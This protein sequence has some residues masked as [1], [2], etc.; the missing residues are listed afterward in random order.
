M[1][2]RIA[3]CQYRLPYVTTPYL[4]SASQFDKYQARAALHARTHMH[5]HACNTAARLP[6]RFQLPYNEGGAMPPYEPGT[7]QLAFADG[8]Q[9]L[10][11]SVVLNLPTATQPRS[12]VF[13]SACFKHCTSNM[14]A[15]WGVRVDDVSLAAY[16][17]AWYFDAP[18]LLATAGGKQALGLPAGVPAQRIEACIGF[19]CGQCHSRVAVGGPPLP[20]A[21]T[22][23]LLAPGPGSAPSLMGGIDEVGASSGA[24]LAQAEAQAPR[25]LRT[26]GRNATAREAGRSAASQTRLK[27]HAAMVVA[28]AALVLCCAG[29]GGGGGG[30]GGGAE[31]AT[32]RGGCVGC[33]EAPCMRTHVGSRARASHRAPMQQL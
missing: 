22:A 20:P 6:S 28:A 29:C 10:V 31:A 13:S 14:G 9:G 23:S 4:L 11:R 26:M 1:R 19:G 12:A 3:S 8:F 25:R 15:F 2:V 30:G 33:A 16:L 27:E 32:A 18:S 17:R 5:A 21:H 7:P 24:M